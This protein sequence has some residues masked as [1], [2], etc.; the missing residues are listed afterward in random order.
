MGSWTIAG[1]HD[2]MD[3]YFRGQTLPSAFAVR[4]VNDTVLITDNWADISANEI[5]SAGG[6]TT[7]GA[8][9]TLDATGFPVLGNDGTDEEIETKEVSWTASAN[10]ATAVTSVTLVADKATDQLISFDNITAVQP[11]NGETVKWTVKLK[12][13]TTCA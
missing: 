1:Y 4:L 3:C 6:Y 12:L 2:M 13:K 5:P 11:L 10:W 8:A 9:L 7:G